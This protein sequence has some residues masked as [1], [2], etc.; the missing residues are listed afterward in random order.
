[1]GHK[2]KKTHSKNYNKNSNK[3][4][5]TIHNEKAKTKRR[6]TANKPKNGISSHLG[7][8]VQTSTALYNAKEDQS[9]LVNQASNYTNHVKKQYNAL[10]ENVAAEA[11]PRPPLQI[12]QN[13]H[14]DNSLQTMMG[15]IM[16]AGGIN[17]SLP[18]KINNTPDSNWEDEPL[19]HNTLKKNTRTND[20]INVLNQQEII[21]G[22]K[23]D[24]QDNNLD[25]NVKAVK[26]RGR[27]AGSKNLAKVATKIS[28]HMKTR[29]TTAALNEMAAAIPAA[30]EIN[31]GGDEQH[32][33]VN[34][35]EKAVEVKKKAGRPRKE[36]APEPS[37]WTDADKASNPL[38]YQLVQDYK[39]THK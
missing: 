37:L 11:R 5:I 33:N 22:E 3:I 27:P 18:K 39:A 31:L 2:K 23:D 24:G 6:R 19:H 26:S 7:Q 32:N 30:D 1:M 20:L 34:L 29:G 4:N 36:K 38:G 21:Q 17:I 12:Q 28:P 16:D 9:D 25:L 15:R 8:H 13:P 10:L 35:N 14:Q